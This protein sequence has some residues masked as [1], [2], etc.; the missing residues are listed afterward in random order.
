MAEQG[1]LSSSGSHTENVVTTEEEE[2][3]EELQDDQTKRKTVVT[4]SF[5]EGTSDNVVIPSA[6]P[7]RNQLTP[8]FSPQKEMN[9]PDNLEMPQDAGVQNFDY[10]LP[11]NANLQGFNFENQIIRARTNLRRS[12]SVN[13]VI[14][15]AELA[16]LDDDDNSSGSESKNEKKKGKKCKNRKREIDFR[17]ASRCN[18]RYALRSQL[19]DIAQVHAPMDKIN[20]E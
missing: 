14:D 3:E 7:L 9:Q 6:P 5:N 8:P 17:M 10:L 15:F 13:D 4:T 18:M 2:E 19:R 1:F 20:T 12:A 16:N 11:R